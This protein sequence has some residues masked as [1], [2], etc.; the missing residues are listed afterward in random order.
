VQLFLVVVAVSYSG[1]INDDDDVMSAIGDDMLSCF[2]FSSPHI[3]SNTVRHFKLRY[4]IVELRNNN[5]STN[6]KHLSNN[7]NKHLS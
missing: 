2:N 5:N 6:D 4:S 3:K 1:Q 7:V